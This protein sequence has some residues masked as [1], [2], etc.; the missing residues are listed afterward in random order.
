MTHEDWDRA[1]GEEYARLGG[2]LWEANPDLAAVLEHPRVVFIR[3]PGMGKTVLAHASMVHLAA[4]GALHMFV[5]LSD[6]AGDF[7][8]LLAHAAGPVVAVT[9]VDG[10]PVKRAYVLDG[11]DEVAG[12]LVLQFLSELDR[13]LSQEP[14]ANYVLTC[15][16]A[17]YE[18]LRAHVPP[19]FQEFFPLGFE[20]DDILDYAS[21][22]G[23]NPDRLHAELDRA[24]LWLE[25]SIP[26]VLRTLVDV[27]V[28]GNTLESTRSE[29]LAPVV[30]GLLEKRTRVG[31]ARQRKAL[32]LL[33]LAMEL[34]SRNELAI[35]DAVRV[36]ADCLVIEPMGRGNSSTN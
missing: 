34:Y 9:T 31:A 18:G 32:Q 36:L 27:I 29:N 16:Q 22:R 35:D 15:R 25:A 17:L 5:S 3:E 2:F 30:D 8:Q 20:T 12:E 7:G 10:Q 6:Y 33:G 28:Q 13:L 26:F 21:K 11:L 1:G 24:N 23:A 4:A 19:S 14:N